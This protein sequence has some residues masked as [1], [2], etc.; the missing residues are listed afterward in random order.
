MPLTTSQKLAT[1]NMNSNN[2]LSTIA[3]SSSSLDPMPTNDSAQTLVDQDYLAKDPFHKN[4]IELDS[5]SNNHKTVSFDRMASPYNNDTPRPIGRTRTDPFDNLGKPVS[6]TRTDPFGSRPTI[7]EESHPTTRADPFDN[8]E[9]NIKPIHRSRTDPFDNLQVQDKIK[10]ARTDPFDNLQDRAKPAR[11]D[12][13][14][15]LQHTS[16]PTNNEILPSPSRTNP[17]S[18]LDEFNS[19]KS[20]SQ[21]YST[22]IPTLPRVSHIDDEEEPDDED[23][24]VMDNINAHENNHYDWI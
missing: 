21:V 23:D 10:P 11:T 13:F 8:L 1:S 20:R 6:R 2:S 3:S 15:N 17:F 9:D 22:Q 4:D 16:G 19:N 14:D 7:P 12:P 24:I 5:L 18:R